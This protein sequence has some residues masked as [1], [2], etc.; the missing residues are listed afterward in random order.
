MSAKRTARRKP[1]APSPLLGFSSDWYW[2]QD[3]DLKFT[4]VEVRNDAAAEQA[5]AQRLIGKRRWETGVEIEDGWDAHRRC[6]S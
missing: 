6:Q 5:L 4:R 3:T 1:A 2:E